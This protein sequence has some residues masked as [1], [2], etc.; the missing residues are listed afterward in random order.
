[1]GLVS[2][3]DRFNLLAITR[4]SYFELDIGRF[5]RFGPFFTPFSAFDELLEMV[6]LDEAVAP[7]RHTILIQAPERGVT[8]NT[9]LCALMRH[10]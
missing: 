4:W 7:W 9:G 3:S 5:R 10:R 8:I 2:I 1:M 6:N